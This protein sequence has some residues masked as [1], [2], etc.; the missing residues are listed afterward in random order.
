MQRAN[1]Q[2]CQGCAIAEQFVPSSTDAERGPEAE[3]LVNLRPFSAS[4]NTQLVLDQR[5]TAAARGERPLELWSTVVQL[6]GVRLRSPRHTARSNSHGKM[7]AP[8]GFEPGMEVLQISRVVHGVLR[9]RFVSPAPPF[10]LV[11]G[12]Y[13][14]TFGLQAPGDGPRRPAHWLRAPLGN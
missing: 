1:E 6:E 3:V 5:S 7:E 14:T 2:G 9:A 8:P 11:F 13:W 10:C 4:R 12:R